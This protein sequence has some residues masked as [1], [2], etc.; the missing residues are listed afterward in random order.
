MN[1]NCLPIIHRIC[2]FVKTYPCVLYN[3]LRVIPMK[4][5][6]RDVREDNGKT[7]TIVAEYLNCTQ[8]TYS[9][10]ETGVSQPSLE[11]MEKLAVYFDTSVDYLLGITDETKPYPRR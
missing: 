5:R 11:T 3:D 8:Q 1:V 6:L 7:Q 10:Y 9:R 2:V 4:L